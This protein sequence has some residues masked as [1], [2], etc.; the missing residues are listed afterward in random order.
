MFQLY[1]TYLCH[2][3][4]EAIR[5]HKASVKEILQDIAPAGMD[6]REQRNLQ[7]RVRHALRTLEAEGYVEKEWVFIDKIPVQ[8]FKLV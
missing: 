7:K 4:L 2:T 1:G 8:H 6:E 3:V 5:R